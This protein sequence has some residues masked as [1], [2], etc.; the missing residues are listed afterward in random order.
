MSGSA[1]AQYECV[2]QFSETDFTADLKGI[3]VPVLIV[4]GDADHVVPIDITARKAV[5]IIP[6]AALTVYEGAPHAVPTIFQD[7]LNADLLTF[8]K[9]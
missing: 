5:Q 8:I 4:H 1:Y 3:D 7:R 6:N 9:A 2:A